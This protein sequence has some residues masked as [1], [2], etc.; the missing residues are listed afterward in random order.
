LT[1]TLS[2]SHTNYPPESPK[3]SFYFQEAL[4]RIQALPG[5]QSAGLTG[6]LPLTRPAV[7]LKQDK[8]I[9]ILG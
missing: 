2:P 1:L 8:F 6:F 7:S 9:N 5:V 4:E 3:R